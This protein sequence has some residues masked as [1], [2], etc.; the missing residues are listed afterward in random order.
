MMLEPRHELSSAEKLRETIETSFRYIDSGQFDKL[1]LVFDEDV[2][3]YPIGRPPIKGLKAVLNYYTQ[4]RVVKDSVHEMSDM[5]A[6]GDRAAAMLTFRGTSKGGKK[7]EFHSVDIFEFKNGKISS[8]RI[9]T[10][11]TKLD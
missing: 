7:M 2:V 9:F 4:D 6:S 1:H 10:D 5:I 8:S 11:L 3:Y